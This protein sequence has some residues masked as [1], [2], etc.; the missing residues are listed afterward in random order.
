M[1]LQ[2]NCQMPVGS[3][4]NQIE[5]AHDSLPRVKMFKSWSE[6]ART[7]PAAIIQPIITIGSNAHLA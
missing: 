6:F 1:R 4:V 5:Y 3:K 7:L 2:S